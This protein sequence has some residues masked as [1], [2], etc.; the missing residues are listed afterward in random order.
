[1]HMKAEKFSFPLLKTQEIVQ[2]L[3]ELNVQLEE[4]DLAKA[5]PAQL[6]HI[7]ELL[8]TDCLDMSKEE[9]YQPKFSGLDAFQYAELHDDSV[10]VLHFVRGM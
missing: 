8:L 4:A 2:C 3:A 5:R 7:Y 10:P 9:L 6:R 1:M